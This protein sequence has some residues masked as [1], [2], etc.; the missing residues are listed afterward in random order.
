MVSKGTRGCITMEK[1]ETKKSWNKEKI[2]LLFVFRI[3]FQKQIYHFI[4]SRIYSVGFYFF[5]HSSH[6]WA[7]QNFPN[8][9]HY[10]TVLCIRRV[11]YGKLFECAALKW[12]WM[13]E[14]KLIEKKFFGGFYWQIF[15]YSRSPLEWLKFWEFDA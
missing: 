12:I 14:K 4:I 6:T 9:S 7:H 8:D 15:G 13:G 2:F 3:L 5:F 10:T 11:T 1:K